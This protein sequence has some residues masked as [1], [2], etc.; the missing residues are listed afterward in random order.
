[1]GHVIA[2]TFVGNMKGTNV[3]TSW[4]AT[5]TLQGLLHINK[6]R[7]VSGFYAGGGGALG[8]MYKAVN[9]E[10][11]EDIS[12]LQWRFQKQAMSA[13]INGNKSCIFVLLGLGRKFYTVT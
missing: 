5:I 3:P 2:P 13:F 8:C 1:M 12:N 9:K 6:I 7:K 4:I 11:D 10:A